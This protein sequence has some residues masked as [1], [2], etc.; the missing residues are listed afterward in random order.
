[1]HNHDCLLGNRR[2]TGRTIVWLGADELIAASELTERVQ[3]L[4][5]RGMKYK[6]AG[7]HALAV[8]VYRELLHVVLLWAPSTGLKVFPRS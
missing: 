5:Q 8:A 3:E 1:M 4:Q 7:D 2:A 6:L